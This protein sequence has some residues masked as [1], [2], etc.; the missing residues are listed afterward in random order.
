MEIRDP[1]PIKPFFILINFLAVAFLMHCRED[2]SLDANDPNIALFQGRV[3][4]KAQPFDGLIKQ[5]FPDLNEV[6]TTHYKEG[7]EDGEYIAKLLNGQLLEQRYFKEGR[8][9]GIHRS[10]FLNGSNR[11]YSE[12]KDGKYIND[13]WEWYDTGKPS[14]YEK[15]DQNSRLIVTKK[16]NRNGQI[17]MNVV[18][19]DNGSSVGM[20]GSKICEPIQKTKRNLN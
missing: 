13:R 14:L 5:E 20:P 19:T 12:F 3:F 17:Y 10:W 4:Y 16:W 7:L 11:Q 6:Q 15:F 8:K 9:E 1:Y 2:L 18:F